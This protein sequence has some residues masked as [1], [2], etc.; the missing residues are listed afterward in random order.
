MKM[1]CMLIN[2]NNGSG[3]RTTDY[4]MGPMRPKKPD[5]DS[6]LLPCLDSYF[7]TIADE[8]PFVIVDDGSTDNSV[9]LIERYSDRLAEFIRCDTNI[10]LTPN[11][12]RAADILI[13]KYGCDVVCRFDGDIEFLS[14]GWDRRICRYFE[15]NEKA[16]AVGGLQ[17][18]PWGEIWAFGDMLIHPRGY[19][20]IMGVP[21]HKLAQEH[22]PV[23]MSPNLILGNMECDSVM[24]C[25]AAFRSAAYRKV[26]GLRSEFDK[27]RGET[28]DLNL[29][30]LLAG[31]QCVALGNVVF[32]HR[33][34]EHSV[35]GTSVYD[36]QDQVRRSFS[37]WIDL[38]GWHKLQP[39]LG[40]IYKRWQGTALTRNL[41]RLDDGTVVYVG[42]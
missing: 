26:G 6:C 11:M 29:R 30:L 23:F 37:D 34:S 21:T 36:T 25:L 2:Y 24:G 31:Y 28:E 4:S 42:P 38:W 33:H 7:G 19:I 9:E 14:E 41:E 3:T 15:F 39:D 18:A 40:A 32:I 20:H 16:G 1:G 13:D 12:V 8:C 27:L 17:L 5:V 10:G 22:T 35:K